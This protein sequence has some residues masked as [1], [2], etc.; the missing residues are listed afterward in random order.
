MED[1]LLY[2]QET[3]NGTTYL[4]LAISCIDKKNSKITVATLENYNCNIY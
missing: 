2:E 4:R 3:F 1:V